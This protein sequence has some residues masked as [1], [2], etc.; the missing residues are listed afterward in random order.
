MEKADS[1]YS[2]VVLA[3]KRARDLLD[4]GKP[5]IDTHSNKYVGSALEE[6][7]AGIIKLPPRDR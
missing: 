2:L 6:I 4:G 1:K 5:Q 7:N 3:A